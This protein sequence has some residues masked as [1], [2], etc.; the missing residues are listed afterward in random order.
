MTTLLVILAVSALIVGIA[1][2]KAPT[3]YPWY[4]PT[5]LEDKS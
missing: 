2:Y 5:Y 4:E 1:M 3:E